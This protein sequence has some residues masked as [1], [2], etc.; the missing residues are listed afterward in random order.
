[1]CCGKGE[2]ARGRQN[3]RE[4]KKK[5][6]S[7]QGFLAVRRREGIAK[8]KGETSSRSRS[9]LQTCSQLHSCP[10]LARTVFLIQMPGIPIYSD[11]IVRSP[12]RVVVQATARE[13][14]AKS[15]QNIRE[16]DSTKPRIGT[17]F[18]ESRQRKMTR[19]IH[20]V[21]AQF[22][23]TFEKQILLQICVAFYE[24]T[25]TYI[26]ELGKLDTFILIEKKIYLN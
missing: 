2:R 7:W 10:L 12:L 22:S 23:R 21:F 3:V 25:I 17:F 14:L 11:Y 5:K 20:C 16:I 6:K 26:C 1:M 9:Y 15:V 18:F 13:K 19:K 24:R 4:S 8:C